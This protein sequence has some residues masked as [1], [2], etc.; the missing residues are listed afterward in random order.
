[1]PYFPAGAC[2]FRGCPKRSEHDGFCDEH[3]KQ[4]NRE[5]NRTR[6]DDVSRDFYNSPTWKRLRKAFLAANPLCRT[7]EKDGRL[8]LATIVDHRVPIKHGGAPL[9][10]ANLQPLCGSCHSRKSV[11]EGSRWPRGRAP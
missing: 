1:M 6:R 3:R 4:C 7:C 8:T 10:W 11:Q 9:D 5:Y 2:R